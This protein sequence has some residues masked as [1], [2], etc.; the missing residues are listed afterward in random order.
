MYIQYSNYS[1]KKKA[2]LRNSLLEEE[3]R[4]RKRRR[5]RKRKRKKYIW[6]VQQCYITVPYCTTLY[7]YSVRL[8]EL[9][10]A[11]VHTTLHYRTVKETPEE[12]K[13]RS[14]GVRLPTIR[15]TSHTHSLTFVALPRLASHRLASPRLD[16]CPAPSPPTLTPTL[17]SSLPDRPTTH[18]AHF[19]KSHS[20]SRTLNHAVLVPIPISSPPHLCPLRLSLL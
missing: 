7:G 3:R 8:H 11:N 4:E 20:Y 10:N 12:E 19:H 15:L 18:P 9:G 5:K 16:R 6:T 17:T 13:V 14:K 2:F 1:I